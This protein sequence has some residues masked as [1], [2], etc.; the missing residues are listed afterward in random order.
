MLLCCCL[1]FFIDVVG[2]VRRLIYEDMDVRLP[3]WCIG[4]T[5]QSA[6]AKKP[7]LDIQASTVPVTET[8]VLH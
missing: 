6:S 1:V 4:T 8:E 3:I 5:G 7:T 2:H